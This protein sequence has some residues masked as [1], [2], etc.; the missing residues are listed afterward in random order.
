MEKLELKHLAPY[1]PY[2]LK[3]MNPISGTVAT[4]TAY[5]LDMIIKCNETPILRP[6]SYLTKAQTEQ[7]A[8]LLQI[9]RPYLKS[10]INKHIRGHRFSNLSY[11]YTLILFENHYDVFGLI[12][13][14]QAIDVNTLNDPQH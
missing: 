5:D 8:E 2:G 10:M 4:M 11:K 9:T 12:D 14:G 1:L 3:F 13:A 7:L 6:L